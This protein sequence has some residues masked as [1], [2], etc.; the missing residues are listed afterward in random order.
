MKGG[1]TPNKPQ[2][3]PDLANLSQEE[4]ASNQ[5]VKCIPWVGGERKVAVTWI[6]PVYQLFSKDAPGPSKK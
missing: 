5:E 6:S 3:E 1:G 4:L 2:P